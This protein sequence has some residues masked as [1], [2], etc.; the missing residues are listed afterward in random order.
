MPKSL[1]NVIQWVW[2]RPLVLNPQMK[3]VPNRTQKVW[4]PDAARRAWSG[5]RSSVR[6]PALGRV[7]FWVKLAVRRQPE[8]GWTVAHQ[9]KH[10]H[11]RQEDHAEHQAERHTPAHLSCQLG[12]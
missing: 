5:E 1:H 3:K 9:E 2:I 10:E 4:L 12:Q 6:S 7:R 8:I 11:H